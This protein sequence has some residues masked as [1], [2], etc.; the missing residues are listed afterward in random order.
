[1]LR[2]SIDVR[3]RQPLMPVAVHV[4]RARGIN[5]NDLDDLHATAAIFYQ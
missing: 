1:L 5:A 3:R 4:I 2:K